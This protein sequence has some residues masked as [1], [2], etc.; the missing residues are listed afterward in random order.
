MITWPKLDKATQ[1]LIIE[2][3]REA[4]VHEGKV[5]QFEAAARALI[6]W[7][8]YC[9]PRPKHD[10]RM[11]Q[12]YIRKGRT[13]SPEE[14]LP[15]VLSVSKIIAKHT[16]G[17]NKIDF[18][19][20]LINMASDRLKTFKLRGLK[21]VHCGIEGVYFVKERTPQKTKFEIY[22]FNLYALDKDG[23][24]VLMTKDHIIPKSKGGQDHINNYDTMCGP[25]N[26]TKRDREAVAAAEACAIAQGK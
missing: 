11:V 17:S 13:Y 9:N 23:K 26:W 19:G 14:V 15:R 3:I 5:E 21:C 16:I 22:H 18:D 4:G 1:T 8:P 25:C 6:N 10:E 12:H 2:H 24:E 20:D 7:M